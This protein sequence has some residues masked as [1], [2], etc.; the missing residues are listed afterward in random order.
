M[1]YLRTPRRLPKSLVTS[2][3]GGRTR[4]TL[5]GLSAGGLRCETEEPVAEMSQ[6]CV[7]IELPDA[8]G[9][10]GGVSAIE[11][12]ATVVECR[13]LASPRLGGGEVA[14]RSEGAGPYELTLCFADLAAGA[15][16]KLL[17]RLVG[18][19]ITARVARGRSGRSRRG[20]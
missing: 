8:G 14:L 13:P 15:R 18:P 9:A 3:V 16:V 12:A 17:D 2:K 10:D 5:R 19:G 4:A 7:W 11:V 20:R 1:S 6:L